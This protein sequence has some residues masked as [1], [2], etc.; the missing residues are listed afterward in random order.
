MFHAI[1]CVSIQRHWCISDSKEFW[2]RMCDRIAISVARMAP[3][4]VT[5]SIVVKLKPVLHDSI[6]P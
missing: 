3:V 2:R 6:L 5:N 4:M 1:L